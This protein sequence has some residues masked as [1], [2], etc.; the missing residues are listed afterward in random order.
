[1][2]A[3]RQGFVS[4]ESFSFNESVLV[5]A[6][7]VLSGGRMLGTFIAAGVLVLLPELARGLDDYRMMFFGAVLVLVMLWRPNGLGGKRI[8]SIKVPA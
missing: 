3:A 6:V 8:P 1:L 2:F 5:L 7:V 4:P